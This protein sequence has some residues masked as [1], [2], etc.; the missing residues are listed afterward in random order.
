M[1]KEILTQC[2]Q[3]LSYI[4]LCASIRQLLVV[5]AIWY[6]Y[7]FLMIFFLLCYVTEA[8]DLK[9]LYAEKQKNIQQMKH[10]L[11]LFEKTV[12]RKNTPR[13]NDWKLRKPETG[14]GSSLNVLNE[15]LYWFSVLS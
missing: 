11:Y 4:N 6:V 15:I 5:K 14:V 1:K 7:D 9:K 12:M 10:L 8:S 3:F 2:S 13:G